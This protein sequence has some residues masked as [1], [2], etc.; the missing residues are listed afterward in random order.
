[1]RVCQSCG[2]GTVIGKSGV[3]RYGG[4]WARR[5]QKTTR[6][7]KPNLHRAKITIDGKTKTVWLC[8][9]CLRRAKKGL[10]ETKETKEKKEETQ[11][12]SASP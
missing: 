2:K 8:T 4:G 12:T 10:K 11:I 9:K 5:A 7:W 3:H 6:V 1:M